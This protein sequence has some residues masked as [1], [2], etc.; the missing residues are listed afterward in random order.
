MYDYIMYD[1]VAENNKFFLEITL[2]LQLIFF[3]LMFE[4]SKWKWISL[5]LFLSLYDNFLYD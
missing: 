1:Y 2:S 5:C 3:L 4:E